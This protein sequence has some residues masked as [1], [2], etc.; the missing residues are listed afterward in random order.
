[1]YKQKEHGLYMYFHAQRGSWVIADAVGHPAP[2]AF[3]D[4]FANAPG[5]IRG[6]GSK[7][8]AQEAARPGKAEK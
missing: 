5:T 4:D 8:V 7:V 6:T 3:V 1:M 2:Y